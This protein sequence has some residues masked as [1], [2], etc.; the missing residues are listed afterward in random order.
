MQEQGLSCT[1]MD[2]DIKDTFSDS[3]WGRIRLGQ[4][5]NQ[6]ITDTFSDSAWDRIRP[7]Q[8]WIRTLKT[9]SVKL[10][11]AGVDQHRDG[12]RTVKTGVMISCLKASLPDYILQLE[13]C[14]P[15]WRHVCLIMFCDRNYV[16]L[17]DDTSAWLCTHIQTYIQHSNVI[18]QTI[19]NSC[20]HVK[21]YIR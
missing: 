17:H 2:Q 4:K 5:W 10:H 11:D 6:H 7:G 8:K 20:W 1:E 9:P 14:F 13:W 18:E 15:P 19:W 21:I 12:L 16:L 3:A